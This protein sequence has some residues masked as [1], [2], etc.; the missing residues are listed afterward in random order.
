MCL[1]EESLSK[2]IAHINSIN[3][4][5]EDRNDIIFLGNSLTRH[6]IDKNQIRKSLSNSSH[7]GY[8]Y[9][10][11]TSIIEWYYIFKSYFVDKNNVPNDIVILFANDQLRS[12]EIEFEEI[13]R[14]SKYVPLFRSGFV[15]NREDLSLSEVIDF[16]LCKAF[17][18][19]ANRERLSKRVL[20][21]LPKYRQLIRSINNNLP[22]QQKAI[23]D[24]DYSHFSDIIQLADSVGCK[25]W[26][27]AMPVQK[28]YMIKDEIISI[29]MNSKYSRLYDLRDPDKYG[30]IHFLDGYHLNQYGSTIFTTN[31]ID[32]LQLAN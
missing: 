4:I 2:D 23:E 21:L 18:T 26:F 22:S 9:P 24:A 12:S 13:Q 14:I 11:D 10:D 31:I 19:Y 7:I 15:L 30:D 3:E 20:D 28:R 8:I 17:S 27:C 6:G 5:A 1:F 32:N 16:Y 29:I 25:I